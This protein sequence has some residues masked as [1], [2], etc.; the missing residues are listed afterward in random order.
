MELP[1]YTNIMPPSSMDLRLW[2]LEGDRCTHLKL[3]LE[4]GQLL[5]ELK[6]RTLEKF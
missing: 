2:R 4:A 5:L 3:T 1:L 6:A